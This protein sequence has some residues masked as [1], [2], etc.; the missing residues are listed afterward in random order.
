MNY[1]NQW[2]NSLEG[3]TSYHKVNSHVV[4]LPWRQLSWSTSIKSTL[5][6]STCH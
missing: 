2:L 6:W 5:I 3:L 1:H 4:N